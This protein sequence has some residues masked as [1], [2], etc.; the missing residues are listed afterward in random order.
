MFAASG[1]LAAAAGTLLVAV[2]TLAV[3]SP[4]SVATPAPSAAVSGGLDAR[5]V[6][7]LVNVQPTDAPAGADSLALRAQPGEFESFQVVLRPA[8]GSPVAGV[9]VAVGQFVGAG[10]SLPAESSTVFR[11]AYTRI[12][13]PSDQEGWCQY[14]QSAGPSD[15]TCG[16]PVDGNLENAEFKCGKAGVQPAV[17][18]RRCLFPDALIPERDSLYG[19]DRNAFPVDVP[20]GENRVAWVDVFVPAV[21]PAGAYAS[22]VSVTD[23][24]GDLVQLPVTLTVAGP[25]LPATGTDATLT[26]AGG[27]HANSMCQAMGCGNS[28]PDAFRLMHLF[29]RMALENRLPIVNPLFNAAPSTANQASFDTWI[30][31]YLTGGATPTTDGLRPDRVHGRVPEILLDRNATAQDWSRWQAMARSGGFAGRMRFYC[32]EVNRGGNRQIFVDECAQ[33]Y[34]RAVGAGGWDLGLDDLLSVLIGRQDH[35]NEAQ[36]WGPFD[37]LDHERTRIPVL[38]SLHP[39]NAQATDDTR[40]VYD[41]PAGFLGARPGRTLWNY[42]ANSSVGAGDAWTPHREWNGWAG[43]SGVDQPPTSEAAPGIASWMYRTTGFYY[44]EAF[45]RLGAAW[46]DCSTNASCLYLEGGHGDGT[47]FYPGLPGGTSGIGGTHSIPIESMRL[48]RYR[49]GAETYSLLRQ[50][51]TGCAGTCEPHSRAELGAIVGDPVAR[52]GLFTSA[53]ATD[54][55]PAAFEAARA[56]LLDLLPESEEPSGLPVISVHDVTVT[57]GE[58][59][60]EVQLTRAG[61][62]SEPSD[63]SF[64]CVDVTATLDQDYACD[65]QGHPLFEAG[66]STAQM[67][68]FLNDDNLAE[69]EETFRVDLLGATNGTIDPADDSATVTIVD[70]GDKAVSYRPDVLVRAKG[71]FV[72]NGVY[73][74]NGTGQT[75]AQSIARGVTREFRVRIQNDGDVSD[76]FSFGGGA[77]GGARVTVRYYVGNRDITSAVLADSY[78]TGVLAPGAWRDYRVTVKVKKSA[79]RKAV[80]TWL[81][82]AV[83]YQA[84]AHGV[85]TKQDVAALKVKVA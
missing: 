66:E 52:T 71:S 68:F 7:S 15:A 67:S 32:D 30:K 77:G 4:M 57:E 18:V 8:T 70:N 17:P 53:Y 2:A 59:D 65:P 80:A 36:G 44:Y 45:A 83:S 60:I 56:Q 28:T 40:D 81:V 85:P 3:T 33:P 22:T 48:K 20:A 29:Q 5:L 23:A 31:P 1:R 51:E 13:T 35:E 76:S 41:A 78:S 84:Y 43:L 6:S 34:E 47:L 37:V 55:T 74:L 11:E 82:R 38:N 46:N 27:V 39:K 21:T 63:V 25:V 61:D 54:V 10:H 69:G 49:D 79:P 73:S 75:A 64:T 9:S 14:F 62:L 12:W 50:L 16:I 19:E 42:Q 24:A 26:L 72:G 58:L